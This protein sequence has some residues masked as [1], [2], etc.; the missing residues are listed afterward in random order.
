MKQ[1]FGALMATFLALA[2]ALSGAAQKPPPLPQ[3][4]AL[5]DYITKV[6]P[7]SKWG[8]W[9]DYQGVQRSSSPHGPY[10]RLYVNRAGLSSSKAPFNYGTIQVKVSLTTRGKPKDV[11]VMYKVKG[12]SPAA[13]DWFWAMYTPQ[14]RPLAAGKLAGCIRCHA[15]FKDNDYVLAHQFR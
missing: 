13:G 12:Y 9:P 1:L 6:S 4:M 14:G 5:W 7:F 3:A 11:M 15:A 2:P 8:Q 10:N